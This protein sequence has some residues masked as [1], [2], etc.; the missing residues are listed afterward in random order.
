MDFLSTDQA[1]F[2]AIKARQRGAQEG[3]TDLGSGSNPTDDKAHE[4]LESTPDDP[5][6]E[7]LLSALDL[8]DI[9][10]TIELMAILYIGRGD[11]TAEE[12]TQAVEAARERIDARTPQHLLSMPL[13]GTYLEEG[14]AELGF[15]CEDVEIDRL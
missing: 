4:A 9:D 7:E 8:L 14:L 10:E 13:L 6:D 12:W 2:I 3:A 11:F 1:C 5:V 15:S